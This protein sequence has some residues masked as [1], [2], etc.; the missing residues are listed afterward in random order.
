LCS[1]YVTQISSVFFFGDLKGQKCSAQ[2]NREANQNRP[3]TPAR[4]FTVD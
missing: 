3:D 4:V 2:G 1:L